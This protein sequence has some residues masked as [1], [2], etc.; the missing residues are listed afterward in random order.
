MKSVI[1]IL[2]SLLILPAS[3]WSPK[4]LPKSLKVPPSTTKDSAPLFDPLHF[5]E[6]SSPIVARE[7]DAKALLLSA[8]ALGT[9]T[10]ASAATAFTPNAV[11]AAFFAYGHYLSLLGI[12]ACVVIERLTIKP[13]MTAEEE[14]LVALADIGTGVWG[15]L[16]AYTGYARVSAEKGFAFYSHEPVFWLKIC[17]V[18]IFGAASFFNTTKIIQRSVSRRQSDGDDFVPMDEA[19]AARMIQICNAELVALAT[20]PLTATFMA[21]GVL[22][23]DSIPW[24]VEAGLAALVFGGLSYKYITEAVTWEEKNAS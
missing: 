23:S 14:D 22:Y 2:I 18:G 16:I 6:Q 17:F 20:I 9:P 10:I 19:L 3:A 11:P 1:V 15:A 8:S 5:D 12:V 7:F 21:R 4:T 24:Q 13:N